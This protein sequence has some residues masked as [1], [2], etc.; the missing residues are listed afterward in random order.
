MHYRY[1]LS[2]ICEDQACVFV[3]SVLFHCAH[4]Q[5][6]YL[7]LLC[8]PDRWHMN[9]STGVRVCKAF[10]ATSNH[11]Q[12]YN[13]CSAENKRAVTVL[14]LDIPPNLRFSRQSMIGAIFL[15]TDRSSIMR[16]IILKRGI[17]SPVRDMWALSCVLYIALRGFHRID[18]DGTATDEETEQD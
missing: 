7:H 1:A 3:I 6:E 5:F 8:R 10:K 18:L 4:W 14:F 12:V 9:P 16:P 17:C 11:T 13:Y 15:R 2:D